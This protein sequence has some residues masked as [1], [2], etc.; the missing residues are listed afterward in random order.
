[1]L[2]SNELYAA[3]PNDVV[4]LNVGTYEASGVEELVISK[5]MRLW[6]PGRVGLNGVI[7]KCNL[8]VNGITENTGE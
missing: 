6:G 8:V 2:Q 4:E 5:P 7:L 1:M 3:Q